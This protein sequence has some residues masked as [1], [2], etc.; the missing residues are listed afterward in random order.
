MSQR[1]HNLTKWR[2][3][4]DGDAIAFDNPKP[5]TVIID[6]N[7]PSEVRFYV[8]QDLETLRTDEERLRDHAAGR[9][10][11]GDGDDREISFVGVCKGRDRLE[12]SVS[13]AFELLVDGG[14][15]YIHSAEGQ[16]TATRVVAPVIFTKIANRRA[17][18]PHLEMIQYEM[19][20]NQEAF[21]ASMQAEAD[22][23]A[24]ALEEGFEAYAAAKYKGTPLGGATDP[25][26]RPIMAEGKPVAADTSAGEAKEQ[27]GDGS[28]A[29]GKR[30]EPA[31]AKDV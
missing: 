28:K 18:N 20:R 31:K 17:R 6:V 25:S 8:Q 29:S 27:G 19:R 14:E 2:S 16:D 22:R 7:C 10:P 4:K 3:L 21:F 1:I 12:F 5:R 15:A 26:G 30:S 9:V 13:G 11:S 24:K 23:R